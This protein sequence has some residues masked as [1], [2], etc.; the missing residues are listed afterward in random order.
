MHH[1][2]ANRKISRNSYN[3]NISPPTYKENKTSLMRQRPLNLPPKG[4]AGA[5]GYSG[6]AAEQRRKKLTR[7][8][9]SKKVSVS[10]GDL[11][12]VGAGSRLS[13]RRTSSPE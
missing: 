11:S 5:P 10:T 6:A 2:N 3:G 4:L 8:T 1:Q 9:A 7:A 12:K 13:N